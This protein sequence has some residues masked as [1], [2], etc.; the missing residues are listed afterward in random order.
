MRRAIFSDDQHCEDVKKAIATYNVHSILLIGTSDKMT[1]NIA[2]RLAL[3]PID[4]F[5]Y[6]KV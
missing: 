5:Y 4:T 6:V 1:K 2:K 3:G